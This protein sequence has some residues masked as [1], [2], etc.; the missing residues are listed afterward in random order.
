MSYSCQKHP[1][2]FGFP[3]DKIDQAVARKGLLSMEIEFSLACNYRCPYCYNDMQESVSALRPDL[4][5]D[6]VLQAKE[7]GAEKII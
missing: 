5:D 4:I 2:E 6:V 1:G 7:L 3:R